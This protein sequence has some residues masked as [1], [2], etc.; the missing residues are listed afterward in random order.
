MS[1]QTRFSE[2]LHTVES[3]S[4]NT[5]SRLALFSDCHRGDNSWTDDFARN[6]AITLH[7]LQTYHDDGF[8]YIELGDGD[9]LLEDNTI[10]EIMRAHRHIFELLD[11]FNA[12]GRL[13]FI[14]GNHN[15]PWKYLQHKNST[16]D[17]SEKSS[18]YELHNG[19]VLK[20]Q[21][22]GGRLFLIHGH[23]GNFFADTLWWLTEYLVLNL[24]TPLQRLGILDP[25]SP[26]QNF[27]IR[28][29]TERC[30]AQWVKTQHLPTICGHTHRSIVPEPGILPYFN[31]GCCIYPRCITNIEIVNDHIALVMWRIIPNR[32]GTLQVVKEVTAGP[33]PLRAYFT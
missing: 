23:Q 6:E 14:T 21:E 7:A 3:L 11:Q 5:S 30:I 17:Q 2:T 26:A 20:H 10:E 32:E 29:H 31:T 8:T 18:R 28:K 13:F 19:L 9:E 15:P 16:A 24:W 12:A 33:Y 22:T 4:I 1:V 27:H 25:M